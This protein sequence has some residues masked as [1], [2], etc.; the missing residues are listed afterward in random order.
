M[1]TSEVGKKQQK[2]MTLQCLRQQLQDE[3]DQSPQLQALKDPI[4]D[5]GTKISLHHR[6]MSTPCP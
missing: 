3:V 4:A 2:L 6:A 1:P 5:V